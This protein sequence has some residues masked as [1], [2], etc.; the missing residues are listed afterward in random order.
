[1]AN[2]IE[3]KA[4]LELVK[5]IS[6]SDPSSLESLAAR[7]PKTANMIGGPLAR[8][9]AG[10]Q[11]APSAE[12][13]LAAKLDLL[14]AGLKPLRQSLEEILSKVLDTMKTVRRI[15]MFGAVMAALAGVVM[16]I[17]SALDVGERWDKVL[18]AAFAAVGGLAVIFSDYFQTAPNG[19]RI[20]TAEEYGKLDQMAAEMLKLERRAGRHPLIKLGEE[21]VEQMI[22]SMD[23]YA[24]HINSLK[25][26]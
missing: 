2:S 14:T 10:A 20:A 13:V 21:E 16:A 26:T 19:R 6:Q 11:E 8:K 24:A 3:V 17:T 4:P 7:H 15:T 5:L 1:M 23:D 9:A 18:A 12:E 22:A 25:V